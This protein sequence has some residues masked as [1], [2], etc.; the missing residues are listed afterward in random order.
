MEG[1]SGAVV[2]VDA[3]ENVGPQDWPVVP[4]GF[5]AVMRPD[6]RVYISVELQEEPVPP[7]PEPASE[8]H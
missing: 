5:R 2:C 6:G 8:N 7:H 1:R 3:M 4:A